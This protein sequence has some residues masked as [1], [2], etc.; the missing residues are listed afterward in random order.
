MNIFSLFI[1]LNL[2]YKQAMISVKYGLANNWTLSDTILKVN[3]NV[4]CVR[5]IIQVE[6]H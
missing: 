2:S 6:E 4:D 5:D 1:I 3:F